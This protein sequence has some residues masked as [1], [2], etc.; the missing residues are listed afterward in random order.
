M[1][2][3]GN[4]KMK[5]VAL[6]DLHGY[7]PRPE[8]FPACDVVCICGDIVPLEYQNDDVA[9]IAWFC[10]EFVPWSDQLPCKKVV[11]IAGNHDFFLEHIM[12]GPV[13]EDGSR[14]CRTASEVLK[15]LLPGDNKG[16]HKLIYL[17]DNSVEIEGKRFYGT[18]WIA[19]LERWAFYNSDDGLESVWS[20]IPKKLDVLLTH[21]PPRV[22][23]MGTVLQQGRYNYMND[24]GSDILYG[25][26]L[27]RDIHYTFCGHVHSGR[28][29]PVEYKNN[30][31]VV[32]VSVKDENYRV[33]MFHFEV[34][35]V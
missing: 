12:F 8:E 28:H 17:R 26:M 15:K 14:K 25:K 20:K 2:L 6:S 27:D 13:R 29:T 7:L 21:M 22:A 1:E 10:L 24:Y 16:K 18:P 30:N 19:D 34:F 31:R 4:G 32:N 5:V 23:E 3:D 11:F 9:S 33:G 35:E